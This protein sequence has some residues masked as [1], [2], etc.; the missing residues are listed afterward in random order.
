MTKSKSKS[1]LQNALRDTSTLLRW[2]KVITTR[3]YLITLHYQV[4][5]TA[6]FEWR[7]PNPQGAYSLSPK[8]ERPLAIG[9][10]RVGAV[11]DCISPERLAADDQKPRQR[12]AH[13]LCLSQFVCL[14]VS[15]FVCRPM[16]PFVCFCMPVFVSVFVCLSLCVCLCVSNFVC[17]SSSVCLWVSVCAC[18]SVSVSAFT[19]PYVAA[20][21]GRG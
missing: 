6:D 9:H 11:G 7:R 14:C 19:D 17:L 1:T 8:K 3:Q 2:T 20:R 12:A 16:S 4:S 13:L 5:W 18:L 15:V 21:P 10:V